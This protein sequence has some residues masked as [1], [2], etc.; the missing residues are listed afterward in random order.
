MHTTATIDNLNNVP[1]EN[2]GIQL[3]QIRQQKGYTVDYVASKLHLRAKIIEL[4]EVGDFNLLPEPVFIKGYLRAYS[5]LLGVA[6]DPFLHIF[7]SQFTEEKKPERALW[8]SKRESHK[9]EHF[10]RWFTLLFAFGV[11]LAISLW[12]HNNRDNH[13]VYSAT[14]EG[15]SEDLSLNESLPAPSE[16]KLSDISQMQDLL[17]PRPQMSLVE[18]VSE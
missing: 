8:Q 4:I 17:T 9:A 6:P 5:K 3:A 14:K 2:P 7:N 12:W 13:A 16:I 18:K 15:L 10:I 11:L 1:M